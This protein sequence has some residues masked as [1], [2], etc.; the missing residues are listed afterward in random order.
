MPTLRKCLKHPLTHLVLLGLALGIASLDSL[1][2]PRSQISARLY[3]DIVHSYQHV[4]PH[5]LGR[6]VRC[7]YSPTCSRYSIAA[8]EKY[9][10]GKGLA[11]TGARLWRCRGGVP[12]GTSD[13]VP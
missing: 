7:R 10:L 9:G 5:V 4:G 3:V 6:Y 2:P 12:L 8:V 11:L 1:R 13:P